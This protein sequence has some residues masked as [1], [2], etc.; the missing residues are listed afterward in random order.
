MSGS[1]G[2]ERG[3][4]WYVIFSGEICGMLFLAGRYVVCY[5]LRGD[6][7]YVIFSGEICGMLFLAGRYVVCYF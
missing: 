6:M 3:D 5:F 1:S 7:W 4:M 2:V